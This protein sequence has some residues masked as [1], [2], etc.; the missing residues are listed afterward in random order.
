MSS[1]SY[2][3]IGVKLIYWM[4]LLCIESKKVKFMINHWHLLCIGY[5]RL[6]N[7]WFSVCLSALLCDIRL[8]SRFLPK[9]L[10]YK[11]AAK[12][13]FVSVNTL[14]VFLG[15]PIKIFAF[16]TKYFWKTSSQKLPYFIILRC[17]VQSFNIKRSTRYRDD[18]GM[19]SSF[20]QS[21]F[22]DHQN[23]FPD[24]FYCLTLP[25]WKDLSHL[26]IL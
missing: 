23:D 14:S 10:S 11:K 7:L 4:I 24:G 5:I 8:Y 12:F 20:V 6:R 18:M 21:N 9:S 22:G 1:R 19:Y 25:V 3:L 17:I 2:T 26:I 15:H 16:N 13:V